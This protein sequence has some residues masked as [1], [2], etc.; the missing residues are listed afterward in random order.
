[1]V[2]LV[3]GIFVIF[4]LIGED[5]MARIKIKDLPRKELVLTRDEMLA[6]VGGEI[7][8]GRGK[9]F[10]V[11]RGGGRKDRYIASPRMG[12]VGMGENL[13]PF[14][15]GLRVAMDLG[16]VTVGKKGD[17]TIIRRPFLSPK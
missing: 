3:Y 15:E 4:I 17:T 5:K 1:M 11:R 7:G 10:R 8:G 12:G 14:E 2:I 9:Q 13:D 16:W 6:V